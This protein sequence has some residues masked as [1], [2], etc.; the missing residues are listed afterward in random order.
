MEKVTKILVHLSKNN[1]AP[2]CARF[3]QSITGHFTETLNDEVE[4]KCSLENNRFILC[5]CEKGRGI[6][7]KRASFC[8]FK[9]LSVAE[10][11]A[12]PLDVQSRG[13][14]VGV[15]ILLQSANQKVLLTRRSSSLRIF[16][17]VWV[18]PGGHVEL[19]ER[20]LDAGLR[21]LREETGLKLDPGDVSAQLLGL[22]E[23]VFPPML[24]R[25]MPQRHH[26]VTY[27]LLNTS[28]THQQLQASLHPEP[29]EVSGCLWVDASLV[30]AIVSAVDGE[31]G[32]GTPQE[33]LAPTISVLEVSPEGGLSESVLP[34]S[35]LCNRAPASGEDVERV[36]TGTKYALEL[37]LK[38]LEG[39]GTRC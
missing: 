35:V 23:S 27:M 2:Q 16:P 11:A 15:A 24:S 26:V 13:V 25:G 3:V 29:A 31:E 22:W 28:L 34:L 9:Y 39:Q 12:I 8:P 36:S 18:P 21:K 30:K 32:S 5:D 4:V 7:L 6:P 10:A 17:N 20:L 33:G 14:D 19:D 37:W 1:V 38:N